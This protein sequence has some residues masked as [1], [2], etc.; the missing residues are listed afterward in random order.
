MP[1]AFLENIRRK[2]AAVRAEREMQAFHQQQM[3]AMYAP[4]AG[5]M[6]DGPPMNALAGMPPFGA[7]D[8]HAA[9]EGF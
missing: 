9:P 8:Q 5:A 7:Q 4:Y 3:A 1:G 6:P 2:A